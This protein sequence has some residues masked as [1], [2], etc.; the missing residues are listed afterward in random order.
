MPVSHGVPQGSILGPLLY[1]LYV[2]DCFDKVSQDSSMTIMYADDTVLLSGGTSQNDVTSA[3]QYLFDKYIQ[4]AEINCLNINIR[5]TK[6][7]IL[8]P[9]NKNTFIDHS[10]SIQKEQEC[11]SITESYMYLGVNVD[12]N[13]NFEGFLKSIIQKVNYK[14]YLF[15]KIRYVLTFAAAVLV[16]KQMVLPFFDYLDI[17]IDSGPKKYVEKLQ[18]LQFRGIKI[19]YQYYIEGRKIKS[20]DEELGL[21]FLN[22]RRKKHLLHMMYNLKIRHPDL[23]DVREKGIQLRSSSNVRFKE[24][25][26]NSEIYIKSPYV[27]GCNLWKQ[28]SCKI[29][30]AET[31]S[32]FKLA[33]TNEIILKLRL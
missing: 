33:L 3:N 8:C 17:L 10:L 12:Q 30:N 26:L 19:I 24:H 23:L 31:L 4:W 32:L 25:K 9:R 6:Q 16:Y 13:L 11:I 28:L 2:N 20:S 29:Q 18:I 22:E 15:S 27:R 1:I 7:L 14:F 21:Q 5:K